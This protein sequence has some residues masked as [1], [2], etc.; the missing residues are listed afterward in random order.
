MCYAYCSIFVLLCGTYCSYIFLL[1]LKIVVYYVHKNQIISS[2]IL[3][4]KPVFQ[5]THGRLM[6]LAG[7]LGFNTSFGS[8]SKTSNMSIE[9]IQFPKATPN[10]S[11]LT[12]CRRYMYTFTVQTII[13]KTHQQKNKGEN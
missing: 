2:H 10:D 5:S 6:P 13:F 1:L 7:K 9:I 12:C 8:Q 4:Q 3:S 11:L